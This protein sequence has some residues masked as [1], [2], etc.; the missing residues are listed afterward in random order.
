ME[1]SEKELREYL[2]EEYWKGGKPLRQ[3]AK[4]L[5]MDGSGVLYWFKKLGIRTRTIK[6]A[7]KLWHKQRKAKDLKDS[8]KFTN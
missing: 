4:D 1:F 6:Q 2:L 3:I 7:I 5:D 8:S